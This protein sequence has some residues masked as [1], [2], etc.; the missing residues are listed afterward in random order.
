VTRDET[1]DAT[2]RTLLASER[3]VLAWL[4]TGLTVIAVAVAIGRIAPE[5]GGGNQ[6]L[7]ALDGAAWALLGVVVVIYGFWRGRVVDQA[8]REGRFV[9]LRDSVMWTIGG[10]SVVMGMLTAVLIV[11]EA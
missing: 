3:T 9:S 6:T 5:L 1:G 4:R 2:R 8:V 7:W 11:V 10:V